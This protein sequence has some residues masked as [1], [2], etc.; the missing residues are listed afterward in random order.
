MAGLDLAG[1]LFGMVRSRDGR[2]RVLEEQALPAQPDLAPRLVPNPERDL[3]AVVATK[4]LDGWLSNRRQTL[5]P[6]T[7]SFAVLPPDQSSLLVAVMAAAVQAD[8]MVEPGTARRVLLTLRRVG[9]D[10][11]LARQIEAALDVPQ[12]LVSLL[13]QVQEAGLATH[14]YA[15]ALL[16]VEQRSRSSRAFLCY[17]SAR[18]GLA[19][20]VAGSLERRYRA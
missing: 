18:L 5:V 17:L 14:A 8:G 12:P 6:H 20:D 9:A 2:A 11:G 13:T 19:P 1:W 4:V 3:Q 15:A 7:L 16:A 10:D